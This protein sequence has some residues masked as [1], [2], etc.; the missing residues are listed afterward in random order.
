MTAFRSSRRDFIK[1]TGALVISF[2][3]A[4]AWSSSALAQAAP[5]PPSPVP[6]PL[7]SWIKIKGDG[8]VQVFTGGVE[9]GAGNQTALSQIVAEELDVAV[10]SIDMVM[11]DTATTPNQGAPYGSRTI[12]GMG[13]QLRQAA[14]EAR[15]ALLGLAS[16]Q[17]NAPVEA[18]SVKGGVV[19]SPGGGSVS[20]A[21]A[22]G[23]Q[24]LNV[25]LQGVM[26]PGGMT[27]PLQ[28][29]SAK[30]K[31][32][33][34]YA[35]VG[36]SVPRVDIPLKVSGAFTFMQDVVVPGMVHARVIHPA[37]IHSKLVSI[38]TFDP[39]V[40]GA[41]VVSNGDFV[42]VIADTEWDAIA[43]AQNLKVVWSDW[44]GLPDM[45]DT[46]DMI[47]GTPGKDHPATSKGDAA[48][49]IAAAPTRRSATYETPFEM[50]ASIGPSCAIADV[51]SDTATIW[52]AFMAPFVLQ[53]QLGTLL[54]MDPKAIR[55]IN[56]E[57]AGC[58]G[59]NGAHL[60]AAEAAVLSQMT[61]KPVRLQWMRHDEHG[62]E[63]KGPAMVQDLDGGVDAS[64]NLVGWSHTVWTPPH[65]A[66]PYP[67]GDFIGRWDGILVLGA[68]NAPDLPYD[69]PNVEIMQ[70]DQSH[71]ADAI[72]TGWLRSPAQ[73][74][75]T[76]AMES[77]LDELASAAGVDPVEFRLR[78]I[79]E[80]RLADVLTAAARAANWDSRPSPAPGAATQ[81]SVAVGR[82]VAVVNR[83][84]TYVA[85]VAQVQVNRSTGAIQV[86]NVWAA[87][88]CGLIVNPKAVQAQ[89]ESNV[90]QATSRTL[91]EEVTFDS[92]NVTSLDWV[93]YPIL[94]FPEVPHIETVL[95]NH[96]E[97]PSSGVGEP[98]T[99]PIGAAISNAVFDATGVRLR[100]MPFRPDRVLAALR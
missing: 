67:V 66:Y 51:Q 18:L 65:Y 36:T 78:Y 12:S 88:D 81:G 8:T 100:S 90:I 46:S 49:A 77:F 71:F 79:T 30:P 82:G 13:P 62:W 29:T 95:I 59:G 10:S 92:S 68:F 22:I 41:K 75:Q 35:V 26:T 20:Y 44:N 99:N 97:F 87:H 76:F 80:P 50:H 57:G 56:V 53:G 5:P 21:D 43:G 17:L 16:K 14:A 93:G 94:T 2:S 52:T 47:R 32:P 1:G 98:A 84:G 60:A 3:M 25:V 11:G 38:G 85:E 73:F 23:N 58:Y 31:D 54:Q 37:G 61:N 48:G 9:L 96:P 15:L 83:F 86:T 89:V 4:G 63:L 28:G 69:V 74:Q 40:P 55:V 24:Q 72:R 42:A 6:V 33:S 7:D 27:G 64:G 19:S 70:Y 39:P 34:Q 91:K 45:S